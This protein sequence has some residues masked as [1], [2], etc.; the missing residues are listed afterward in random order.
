MTVEQQSLVQLEL[1][2]SCVDKN[3][4]NAEAIAHKSESV[5][6]MPFQM[7]TSL[8]YFRENSQLTIS[9]VVLRTTVKNDGHSR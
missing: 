8:V 7:V 6:D 4:D 1:H 9:S 2:E 5:V 3:D